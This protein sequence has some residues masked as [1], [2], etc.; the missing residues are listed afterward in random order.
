MAQASILEQI[1]ISRL[2]NTNLSGKQYRMV[3]FSGNYVKLASLR[4]AV[5]GIL[6]NKPSAQDMTALVCILGIGK[7]V[8][9]SGVSAGDTFHSDASGR[10]IKSTVGT[11]TGVE[12]GGKALQSDTVAGSIIQCLVLPWQGQL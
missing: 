2:A 9:G 7:V 10:A 6:M 11:G 12:C 4:S 3:R 1:T 8:S 5:C